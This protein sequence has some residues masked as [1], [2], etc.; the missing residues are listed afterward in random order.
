M[1]VM[2]IAMTPSLN[3]SSQALGMGRLR[4]PIGGCEGAARHRIIR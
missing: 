2:R 1:M 3:A 4:F